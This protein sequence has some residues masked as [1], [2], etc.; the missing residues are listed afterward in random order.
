MTADLGFV[1]H[2]ADREAHELA[3]HRLRDRLPERGLADARRSDEAQDRPRQ[4]VLQ[5]AHGEVLDDA[6]LDLLEIVVVLVEDL[7][8]PR[9]VDLIR[10]RDAPR[11]LREPV[12]VRANHAVLG[13]CRRD[14][15]EPVELAL[16]R[17]LHVLGHVRVVD[18]LAQLVRF[19]LLRIGFAELFL[20]RPHLLA[21]VELALVLLHLALDVGLDLVAQLDDFEL[22]GDH[23]REHAQPL[24]GVAL[25]EDRLTVRRLE[26]HRRGDEVREQVGIGDVVDLHLHLAR[27]LRQIA[28]QLLE[29]R[30]QVAVH[31]D[32]LLG[33]ARHVGQ[34]G[35]GR[36]HV[37]LVRDEL[38]DAEHRAAGDDAAQRAVGNLQHLLD[39]ADRADAADV[40]GRRIFRIL[41]LERD[42]PDLLAFAQR[43][44]DQLDAGPL[45]DRE[46]DDG[47][48]KQHR[49]LKRKDAENFG[50]FAGFRHYARVLMTVM[51]ISAPDDRVFLR[52]GERKTDREDAV[53]IDGARALVVNEDRERDAL[54]ELAVLNLLAEQRGVPRD[55][56]PRAGAGD[57]EICIVA[58]DAE[59]VRVGAGQLDVHDDRAFRLIEVNVGVGLEP[60]VRAA[61]C[62]EPFELENLVVMPHA[63]VLSVL[64]LALPLTQCQPARVSRPCLSFQV[65]APTGSA[66]QSTASTDACAK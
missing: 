21:K 12:E 17:L 50:S 16:R 5:L 4:L 13:R 34:L 42:E 32:D 46:R 8:R 54:H 57:R 52:F 51:R 58:L 15:G 65:P 38:V 9:D 11:Q 44:F 20:D 27:R 47:V 2:A 64:G 37:R 1:A 53:A 63:R 61:G 3:A 18:L 30:A 56:A 62:E 43:L 33:L 23:A 55:V 28:E 60:A 22:L 39:R 45:H 26:P 6:I 24:R 40:V 49:V 7:A 25:F 31:R 29:Q 36:R 14:F 35:E 10:R 19:G 41:V 59:R 66:A 48:R